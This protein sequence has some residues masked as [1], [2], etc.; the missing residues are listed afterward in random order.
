MAAALTFPLAISRSALAL[1]DCREI[2]SQIEAAAA[3]LSGACSSG[4]GQASSQAA[5]PAQSL[6]AIDLLDQTLADLSNWLTVL[7]EQ[8]PPAEA[9]A[10][11]LK[12]ALKLGAM[13]ARLHGAEA[14]DHSS[15]SLASANP[16]E[17]PSIT[18][19]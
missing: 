14:G 10:D 15:P 7:A 17:P 1:A 9:E 8:A 16:A 11:R 19:F 3:D 6:Q 13:R 4:G 12:A 5:N 18:L 2:L